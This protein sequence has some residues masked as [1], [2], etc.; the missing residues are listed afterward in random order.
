MFWVNFG[1]KKEQI[2][3]CRT[4]YQRIINSKNDRHVPKRVLNMLVNLFTSCCNNC[5]G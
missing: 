3:H 2:E 5:I 1:R 4:R